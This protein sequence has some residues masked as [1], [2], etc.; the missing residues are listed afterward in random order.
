MRRTGLAGTV[1]VE[2]KAR[3]LLLTV[4]FGLAACSSAGPPGSP[5]SPSPSSGSVPPTA[6][7]APPVNASHPAATSPPASG[8]PLAITIYGVAH[9]RRGARLRRALRHR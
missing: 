4:L 8:V 6:S 7:S 5:A 3:L 1:R 2:M 9:P